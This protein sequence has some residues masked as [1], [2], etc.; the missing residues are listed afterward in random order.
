MSNRY[1]GDTAAHYERHRRKQKKWLFEAKAL[2]RILFNLKDEILSV[3]DAPIGTGRF[4]DLYKNV[5]KFPSVIGYDISKDMLRQASNKMSG[6]TLVKLDLVQDKIL[7]KADLVVCIR[8]LNLVNFVN[9]IK[10]LSNLLDASKKYIVFTMRT[11]PEGYVGQRTVGRVYLH[12]DF[13][14]K[15]LLME[16][17]FEIV[18]RYHF[19]D[20]VPGQYDLILCK[21]S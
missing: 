16:E 12:S 18:E 1:H 9:T 6:A 11:V 4:L 17:G 5:Y 15:C 14:L 10:A 8:F 20:K 3:I 21:R 19:Q 7:A 13:D 2:N